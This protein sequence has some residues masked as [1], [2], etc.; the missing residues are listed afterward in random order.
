MRFQL[1]LVAAIC[2]TPSSTPTHSPGGA[3]ALQSPK[4]GNQMVYPHNAVI[5]SS[6]T[7]TSAKRS[8]GNVIELRKELHERR[9]ARIL[10]EK[11]A[12]LKERGLWDWITDHILGISWNC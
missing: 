6:D 5:N 10:R 1:L 3:A 4:M 8:I 9:M 11:E 7:S 12:K 2:T